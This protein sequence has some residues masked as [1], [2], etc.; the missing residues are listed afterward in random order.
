MK[1]KC[2]HKTCTNIIPYKDRYCPEHTTRNRTQQ[3]L[4]KFPEE[5]KFY[6]SKA[7]RDLS[8]RTRE[9]YPIC[10]KC[11]HNLSAVVDHIY[12]IRYPNGM[13]YNL[14]PH[15]VMAVCH[16]CHNVKTNEVAKTIKLIGDNIELTRKTFQYLK[17]YLVTHQQ[18]DLIEKIQDKHEQ[19]EEIRSQ[20]GK[21]DPEVQ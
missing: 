15:N 9:K 7:W 18:L 6:N 20:G 2:L 11:N 14:H 8:K 4:E 13:K 12:E 21:E 17:G 19:E 10:Q 5:H 16:G 3:P 1:K